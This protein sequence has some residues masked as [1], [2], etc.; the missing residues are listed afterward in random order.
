[1][2]KEKGTSLTSEQGGKK[3][4]G[5]VKQFFLWRKIEGRKE[6]GAKEERPLINLR[7]MEEKRKTNFAYN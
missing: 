6:R 1:M 3:K 2:E 7:K 4:K 5:F